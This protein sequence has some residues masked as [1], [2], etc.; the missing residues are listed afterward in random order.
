M[1]TACSVR[2]RHRWRP[3]NRDAG[4]GERSLPLA[5]ESRAR[6]DA[7]QGPGDLARLLPRLPSSYGG[8][9]FLCACPA[10]GNGNAQERRDHSSR[11]LFRQSKLPFHGC[12]RRNSSHARSRFTPC[13]FAHAFRQKLRRD[14]PIGR[15]G[16]EP[17]E[18]KRMSASEGKATEAWL[19]D[20]GEFI[21]TFH[22]PDRLTT[23]CPGP[24]AVQRCS[25]EL[26]QGA[27]D[28]D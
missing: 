15:N 8:W 27:A 21:D 10:W 2:P 6:D 11:S 28:I 23:C 7:E 18:I 17:E 24:S 5:G 4:H 19:D 25:D 20:C 12:G 14:N 3:A 22:D 1:D 13:Y 9:R 26:L 16:F